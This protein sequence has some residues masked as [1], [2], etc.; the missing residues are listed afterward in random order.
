[1]IS[2][3]NS[4]YFNF[5]LTLFH[6]EKEKVFSPITLWKILH[7]VPYKNLYKFILTNIVILGHLFTSINITVDINRKI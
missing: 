3:V 6:R 1:M 5:N 2:K 7:T 4:R